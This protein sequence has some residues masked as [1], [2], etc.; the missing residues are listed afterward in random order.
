MSKKIM[1]HA[2]EEAVKQLRL[3]TVSKY[4][5][6]FGHLILETNKALI[7]HAKKLEGEM[8]GIK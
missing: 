8:D 5:K 2:D 6:L 1:I 3:A 7:E 4:G